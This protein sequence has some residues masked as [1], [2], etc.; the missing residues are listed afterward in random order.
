MNLRKFVVGAALGATVLTAVPALVAPH[1]ASASACDQLTECGN[2]PGDPG[3]GDLGG[4]SGGGGDVGGGGGF[5]GGGGGF[6]GGGDDGYFDVSYGN[7]GDSVSGLPAVVILG[8]RIVDVFTPGDPGIPTETYFASS[9]GGSTGGGSSAT[10][11]S[12]GR[13]WSEHQ[14]CYGNT[15][16]VPTKLTRTAQFQWSV[17]V[18]ANLSA[19]AKEVLTASLG[20][21]VNTQLTDTR[22]VEFTLN[23]GDSWALDVEYQTVVYQ[24]TMTDFWGDYTK[25]YVNVTKP[26]G[27]VNVTS[28][29]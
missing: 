29:K 20:T 18:S 1:E 26:T 4:G 3:D 14:N 9:A 13:K 27:V 2:G 22:T 8:R 15:S 28:C 17:K 19:K 23:P 11:W 25:E 5:G 6:G 24:I 7:V 21:E 10:V 12:E 16:N